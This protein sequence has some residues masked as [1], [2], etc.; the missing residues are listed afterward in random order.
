MLSRTL[1]LLVSI[2]AFFGPQGALGNQSDQGFTAIGVNVGSY[3]TNATRYTRFG[4]RD[5][6]ISGE[7]SL[8]LDDEVASGWIYH[9]HSFDSN[10]WLFIHYT[11]DHR[12]ARAVVDVSQRVSFIPL[13][14]RLDARTRL[15]SDD[16]ELGFGTPLAKAGGFDFGIQGGMFVNFNQLEISSQHKFVYTDQQTLT[17][18]PWVGV[19]AQRNYQ[20]GRLLIDLSHMPLELD[21]R[22]INYGS[23][24]LMYKHNLSPKMGVGVSYLYRSF[25]VSYSSERGR[26]DYRYQLNAPGIFLSYDW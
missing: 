5:F 25:N 6:F 12:D 20:N 26:R 16:L 10:R 8:D 13:T 11:R 22:L 15:R 14:A 19:T 18:F 2:V 17:S 21:G 9:R 4:T 24:R 1:P 23:M 3:V 7:R